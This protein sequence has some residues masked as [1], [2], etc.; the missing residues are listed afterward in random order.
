ML[1]KAFDEFRIHSLRT[2]NALR[3]RFDSA[4]LNA[5]PIAAVP[6]VGMRFLSR[7]ASD[8]CDQAAVV[9]IIVVR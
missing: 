5:A 1:H 4:Y 7:A 9:S 2:K 3:C 8:R 6:F